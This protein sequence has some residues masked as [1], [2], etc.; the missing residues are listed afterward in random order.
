MRKPQCE[1][2][3]RPFK[4]Q[5]VHQRFCSRVCRRANHF[6]DRGHVR[7]VARRERE[8]EAWQAALFENIGT[9][10][11]VCGTVFSPTRRTAK[12]CSHRCR[13]QAYRDR[14]PSAAQI[15]A[16]F[17]HVLAGMKHKL[18]SEQRQ[19]LVRAAVRGDQAAIDALRTMKDE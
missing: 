12:Y 4:R 18:R 15:K 2:C 11:D 13:Q 3:A 8:H 6:L 19:R 10:C 9:A 5:R 17:D 7:W 14:T 1:Y 16:H